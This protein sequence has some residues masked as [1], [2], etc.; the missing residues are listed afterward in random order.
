MRLKRYDYANARCYFITICVKNGHELLGELVG[1]DA[2]IVPPKVMYSEYGKITDQ[3]IN[4][5]NRVYTDIFVD[6][7]VNMPNHVHMILVLKNR[8]GTMWASSPTQ[9]TIPNVIRSLKILI[10][11][12]CGFSL[13]Q[14]SYHD[15]IIRDEAEYQKI[16]HYIDQN[17]ARWTKDR[18]YVK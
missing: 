16:Y 7:Y 1:D 4:R 12:K 13:W 17:P 6:K 18:Y 3:F 10:A 11:K 14:R 5:I 9:T 8:S 2:H 15:H